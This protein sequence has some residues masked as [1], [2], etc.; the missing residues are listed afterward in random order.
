MLELCERLNRHVRVAQP[1]DRFPD[2]RE[3]SAMRFRILFLAVGLLALT[4]LAGVSVLRAQGGDGVRRITP[5]ELRQA[6]LKNQAVIVDV[7]NESSYDEG[8][9]KGARLIPINDIGT[10]ASELPRDKIIVTYCA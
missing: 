3:V 4:A 7:R 6:I 2:M 5:A 1:L 8:H 9:I 10:R